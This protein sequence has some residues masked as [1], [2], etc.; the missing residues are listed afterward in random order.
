[1]RFFLYSSML[2]LFVGAC[3]QTKPG[4]T[5]ASQTN[6]PAALPT[7]PPIKE[8]ETNSPATESD[9][10]LAN[11]F[12]ALDG[13]WRGRFQIYTD[14]RGQQ[15]GPRPKP[16]G[17]LDPAIFS[18]EP[19]K[20]SLAIDVEQQYTS[21]SPFFQRVKIKDTYTEKNGQT[22]VVESSGVN[23][24]QDGK[25]WCLVTKPDEVVIHSGTNPAKDTIEWQ[26]D[27][28]SPL[29]IEYFY[30]SVTPT[31]YSIVGY[32]Y[33]GNDKPDLMPRTYFYAQ[34]QKQ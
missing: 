7:P 24:V 13:T 28:K 20:L 3:E 14:S 2:F 34:Y 21:E 26:R 1:V 32:G 5:D 29:K 11:V 18:K 15:A 31:T 22:R 16:G 30:E 4:P 9:K 33:Y 25:L 23:K 27:L 12:S 10:P 6:S 8:L 17:Q 19:Y